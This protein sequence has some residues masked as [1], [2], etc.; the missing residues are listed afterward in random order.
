MADGTYFAC[1][2]VVVYKPGKRE[3]GNQ[4]AEKLLKQWVDGYRGYLIQSSLD[5]PDK[6]IYITFWDSEK[7]ML[8][9]LSEVDDYFY[10]KLEELTLGCVELQ[11][12]EI[13]DFW[14]HLESG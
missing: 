2:T 14:L 13:R 7:S 9:S 6:A 8:R 5:E 10:S 12:T 11:F 1:S 3:D 4:I